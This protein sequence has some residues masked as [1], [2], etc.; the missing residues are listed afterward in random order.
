MSFIEIE[1]RDGIAVLTVSRGKV[2]AI[3]SQLVVDLSTCLADLRSDSHVRG[4]ILTGRGKFFSFGFDLPDLLTFSRPDLKRFLMRFTGLLTDLYLFPKPVVGAL[5]GHATAGG[6]MLALSL[7]SRLMVADGARIALNEINI[8]VPVFSGPA[9]MLTHVVGARNAE[10]VLFTG[11]LFTP[12]QALEL[13]LLDRLVGTDLITAAAMEMAGELAL[14]SPDAYRS[15]K[16]M[17]RRPV[18]NAYLAE[19]EKSIDHWLDVWFT[20]EAQAKLRAVEIR[21]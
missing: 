8:G 15:L 7:D 16:M 20:D 11:N 19:E 12:D 10:H 1:R 14:K 9:A 17:I 3:N 13:G 18:A 21:S 2:N 5:N 6:C 4:V